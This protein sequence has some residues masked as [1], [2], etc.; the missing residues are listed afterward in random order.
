MA[1]A[2]EGEREADAGD[3]SRHDDA[4]DHQQQKDAEMSSE[5]EAD[6]APRRAQRVQ[7]AE[8]ARVNAAR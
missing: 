2:S 1:V 4:D 7:R 8:G 5:V 6:L 3:E